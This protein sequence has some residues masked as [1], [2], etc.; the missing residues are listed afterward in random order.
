ME[1][2]GVV[3]VLETEPSQVS[4]MTG[5]EKKD[6][7]LKD[8]KARCI[9]V[10]CVSDRYIECL[11][12]SVTAREMLEALTAI[13]ERKSPLSKLF[14]MKKLMK[15][16]FNV[17]ELQDHF[18]EVES[19]LRE[20]ESLGSKFDESDKAC[21]LLLTMPE[22]YEAVI[23]AL[24]TMSTA[25]TFDFVKS[26]LLDAELK[27]KES[28]KSVSSDETSFVAHK[29]K[30]Y[31][32][33]ST[34]HF[35]RNCPK[36]QEYRGRPG[37]SYR[38]RGRGFKRQHR[39]GKANFAENC[40]DGQ[41]I[42]FIAS[43]V[44]AADSSSAFKFVLDSGATDHIVSEELN[45][46]MVKIDQLER[47]IQIRLA[48]G[49]KMEAQSKGRLRLQVHNKIVNIEALIVK[50]LSFNLLSVR[51]IMKT[52]FSVTF[53]GSKA[54]ISDG[55]NF[56]LECQERRNLF[57]ADFTLPKSDSV[58]CAAASVQNLGMLWHQR[59]GHVN[60]VFLK[61]MG[62]PVCNEICSSCKVGKAKRTPFKATERPRSRKKGELIYS[63]ISGPVKT[64]TNNNEK[65][66]QTI[67][68]DYTH[69]VTVYLL[70]AKSEAEDSLMNYVRNLEAEGNRCC[71]IRTDCGGEFSSSRLK[72]FC[73]QKG[74][75]L[76]YTLP[77]TQQENGVSERAN[78]TLMSRTR[79]LMADTGLPKHLWGEAIR[80]AAYQLNRCPTSVLNFGI[81]AEKFYGKKVDLSKLKVF[82]S[83]AWAYKLPVP[84][85][86]L[87]PRAV[88]C[89]LVSYGRVGYRLWNPVTDK[90]ITS[91]DVSFD[92]SNF[93]YSPESQGHVDIPLED[94][95]AEVIGKS[96][97]NEDE[98]QDDSQNMELDNTQNMELDNTQ[99]ME[100]DDNSNENNGHE[101]EV[102]K[103]PSKRPRYLDDYEVY[104]AFCLLTSDGASEPNSYEEAK[105]QPE[106][107]L[108][109]D[110]ELNSLKDMKTWKEVPSTGKEKLVDTKWVFRVKNDGEKKA[111][112]VARGFLQDLV[113]DVYAPVTRLST[114]RIL[115]SYALN[116]DYLISQL[117]IPSA[118][119]N[120]D[121]KSSVFIK[122]PDG[123]KVKPG[124]VLK[125]N[126]ALYGLKDAPRS[127]YNTIHSFL[128][129]LGFTQSLYDSCLYKRNDIILV[130]F[131][132]DI[133][134]TGPPKD[135]ASIISSL[136]SK[137]RAKD[138]GELKTYLGIQVTRT[139][140][141]ISLSQAD[142]IKRVLA[143]F[144]MSS[145]KGAAT[146]MESKLQIDPN[147]E[148]LTGIPYRE[149]I[150]SLM[151]LSLGSRPDIA[152]AVSY[153][154]QFLDKP[155]A[156]AWKAGKRILK[157]LRET[158]DLKLHFYKKDL[159][160]TAYSDAD[161][162][163]DRLDRRSV[164]GGTIFYRG[165][166]VSWFSRKQRC[167]ALSSTEAE[168]ISA[169]LT[170]SE[171]IS[172][173]GI[174]S[175]VEKCSVQ[176]TLFID[177]QGAIQLSKGCD[178]NK[179]TRHI[180]VKYHFLKDL[181]SKEIIQTVY[182][183]S[184][185]NLS[186]ILTKSLGPDQFKILRG[187]LNLM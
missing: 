87:E 66:F 181:V 62:L 86:K 96:E 64:P 103:R 88:E 85:D 5:Q 143:K 161:W 89:R 136:K 171:V 175:E 84:S 11:K 152:Y 39:S 20:L 81:P 94:K 178:N 176:G 22:K 165:N 121:L 105:N 40:E 26:R 159:S 30:C 32:C 16:K 144:N 107:K 90:I 53:S 33:G 18:V 41:E 63:D 43:T 111:R 93:K 82:G 21:Y 15:M 49:Q 141:S 72:N 100:Q 51:K 27:M 145:C 117:D 134:V 172:V 1:K 128:I 80:C 101:E 70:K 76:E 91:R 156:S 8:S 102:A 31:N 155:T 163:S 74:I 106:W 68:D 126:K 114:V 79:T 183:K 25:I 149:L 168:Y 17:G 7:M 35:V 58:S 13:F 71:R 78:F 150:G 185:E 179:R 120:G 170:A 99:N 56:R 47:G 50:G 59:L 115:I 67:I 54:V 139:D 118:F 36:N 186:D 4:A 158:K 75:R 77:Y 38:G 174:V 122:P 167:V 3:E 127:W 123:V 46:Y 119:L 169:A 37:H 73:Q 57:F 69:F 23:T 14:I 92:E 45:R 52:G 166:P 42:S 131:V 137:F 24:E 177:N 110:R 138:M 19:L 28:S 184:S 153:L 10:Q 129:N 146:P 112:L 147:E 61:R 157:Y 133:L 130:L 48:N 187:G 65:Y 148:I 104:Q 132:D 180:D 164:S 142:M 34:E 140:S 9:I 98:L 124:Y 173:L 109:V 12:D 44:L 154:S 6:W 116:K 83:K 151:Y 125:L 60:N 29:G 135:I 162:A 97:E 160:V 108:A 55:N 113:S 95:R 182:V 2:D